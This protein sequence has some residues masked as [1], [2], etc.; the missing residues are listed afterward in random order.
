MAAIGK[1]GTRW[2]L[3]LA[4]GFWLVVLFTA[5]VYAFNPFGTASIDPRARLLGYA[6]Y[7]ASSESMAPTVS[8]GDIVLVDT[9]AFRTRG[10]DRGDIVAFLSA[11]DDSVRLYRVAVLP[12]ES[13]AIR[14]GVLLIDGQPQPLPPGA[15]ASGLRGEIDEMATRTM[16]PDQYF[17]LGDNR[18][19]AEDS[20]YTGPVPREWLIGR[21]VRVLR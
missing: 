6:T 18:D 7:R 13:V 3:W 5:A 4:A 16:P 9:K 12:G 8:T 15:T 14:E 17:L 2:L 11:R 20:R 19:F 21:V 10:P 1:T